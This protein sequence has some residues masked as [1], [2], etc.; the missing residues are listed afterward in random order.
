MG[1]SGVSYGG[2]R[3]GPLGVAWWEDSVSRL[4]PER[5]GLGWSLGVRAGDGEELRAGSQAV[6]GPRTLVR[7]LDS[8][9]APHPLVRIPAASN[10]GSDEATATRK[11]PDVGDG[12]AP[13]F[14]RG[15]R[16][17]RSGAGTCCR[18]LELIAGCLLPSLTVPDTSFSTTC[19]VEVFR[20]LLQLFPWWGP[21][22][23][24][25]P[26]LGPLEGTPGA[27][28]TL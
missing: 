21:L 13:L 20:S 19:F 23:T 8:S 3:A 1:S 9:P 2:P 15:S 4:G 17:V 27:P 22:S 11:R 6:A 18:L 12:S 16:G 28:H 14:C 24:L 26:A 10:S 7:R 25:G 5:P